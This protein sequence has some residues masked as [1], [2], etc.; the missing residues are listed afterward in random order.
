M[1]TKKFVV[2]INQARAKLAGVTSQDIAAS[3]KAILTG[4]DVGQFREDDK[5]I[6]IIL[7][8]TPAHLNNLQKLEGHF[9]ELSDSSS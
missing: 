3:L 1:Q 8:N 6:P 5:V 2:R 7:R 4:A 9:A